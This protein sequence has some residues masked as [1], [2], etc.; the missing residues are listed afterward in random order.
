M[1][2]RIS[3]KMIEMNGQICVSC[4]SVVSSLYRTVLRINLGLRLV[5]LALIESFEWLMIG[6]TRETEP[7]SRESTFATLPGDKG[8]Q[9]IVT[10]QL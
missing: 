4:P 10:T 1:I 8:F 5:A 3:F 6:A 7:P 9:G 2:F